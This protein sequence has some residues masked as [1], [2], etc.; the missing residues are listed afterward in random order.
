MRSSGSAR[1]S[2]AKKQSWLRGELNLV[3]DC[4]FF[5]SLHSFTC[6]FVN[7]IFPFL[8]ITFCVPLVF[9]VHIYISGRFLGVSV[10][11]MNINAIM[12]AISSRNQKK[13]V[14]PYAEIIKRSRSLLLS[15]YA[16]QKQSGDKVRSSIAAH[17]YLSERRLMTR[18]FK[19]RK[20]ESPSN[21]PVHL[22]GCE[23]KSHSINET[24]LILPH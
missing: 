8:L 13:D 12:A 11:A 9:A 15:S 5:P 23:K 19:D 4:T 1:W 24:R 6:R 10:S 17:D 3:L 22:A 21:R 18:K 16:I 2:R 7:A 14:I 20:R